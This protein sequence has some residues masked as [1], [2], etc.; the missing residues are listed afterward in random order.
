MKKGM[1]QRREETAGPKNMGSP[2]KKGFFPDA[3]FSLTRKLLLLK[4]IMPGKKWSRTLSFLKPTFL[5]PRKTKT[6]RKTKIKKE[7]SE[8]PSGGKSL[9]NPM[10]SKIKSFFTRSLKWTK[11]AF[12]WAYK[13]MD[14]FYKL[15]KKDPFMSAIATVVVATAGAVIY[16]LFMLAKE[17]VNFTGGGDTLSVITVFIF[18]IMALV[19]LFAKICDD[20]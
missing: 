18:E 5:R 3:V 16:T 9:T 10:L 20:M 17:I 11:G 7:L 4:K 2:K 1:L 14:S 15:I 12:K 13:K 19:A 6:P 8:K